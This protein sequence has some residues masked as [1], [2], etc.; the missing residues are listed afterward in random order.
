MDAVIVGAA[1]GLLGAAVGAGGAIGAAA[2]AG[3]HQAKSQKDHWRRQFRWDTYVAFAV[4]WSNFH[5]ALIDASELFRMGA[6]PT[7]EVLDA[8]LTL[9]NQQREKAA[10]AVAVLQLDGVG[11]V[12]MSAW[13]A[14]EHLVSLSHLLQTASE[15]HRRQEAVWGEISRHTGAARHEYERFIEAVNESRT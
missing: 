10:D 9:A 1:A 8:A 4:A 3:R 12:F 2:L 6:T 15:P 5:H 14:Y 11:G 7:A 13:Q